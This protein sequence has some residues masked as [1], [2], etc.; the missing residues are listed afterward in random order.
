G[1]QAAGLPALPRPAP[2]APARE[3]ARE[4]RRLLALRG[5]VSRGLHPGRGRRERAGQPC[6]GGREVCAHLRDQPLALHLLRLLR[7]RLPVRRDHARQRVRD[8]RVQPRRPHLHEGHAPRGADQEGAGRGPRAVRHADPV[9]RGPFLVGNVVVWAVW[10]V[11]AFACVA[12]ALAVVSFRNPFYSAL[13]LIGNLAS[14]AVLYLLRSAEFVA[15][16]QVLVY[17]GAVMVMFLFVIAYL[18]GR[19]DAPWAGGPNV[20]RVAA[21]TA[22]LAILVEVLVVLG[23]RAGGALSHAA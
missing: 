18:G 16:A 11:A 15:A 1:V 14:L 6:V 10:F 13:A 17:A 8:L 2:A 5:R 9:L 4:V 20:N 12:L 23:L 22:A 7:A 3:R 21:V 19:A